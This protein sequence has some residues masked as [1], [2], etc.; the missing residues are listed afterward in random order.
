MHN[1]SMATLEEVL[2]FY[3]RGGNFNNNFTH[4]FVAEMGQIAG[5]DPV[6]NATAIQKRADIVA[7]LKSLT[8]DRVKY[9]KA[10]FD[11]PELT[12]PNGHTG[13]ASAVING[14]PLDASLAIDNN[15]ILDA[16]GANG[17]STPLTSFAETLAP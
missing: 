9:E 13:N 8:D 10:P 17:R 4:E 5:K 1:G 6:L 16:V 12:I 7:F 15:L 11:H 14:N 2:E 3:A